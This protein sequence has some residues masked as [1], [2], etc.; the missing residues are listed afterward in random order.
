MIRIAN[1]SLARALEQGT[2]AS[3]PQGGNEDFGSMLMDAMKE[4]NQ[5]Q[6]DAR[7]LQNSYLAGQSGVEVH[8]VMI[9]MERATVALQLTMQVRNKVLEAYQELNRMQV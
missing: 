5:S 1:E 8:D 6:N 7:Q 4:V 9:A 2:P 3:K